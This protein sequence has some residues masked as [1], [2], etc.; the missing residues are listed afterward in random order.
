MLATIKGALKSFLIFVDEHATTKNYA[1]LILTLAVLDEFSTYILISKIG[2]GHEL[3]RMTL[4]IWQRLG[5]NTIGITI[6]FLTY[7]FEVILVI[8]FYSNFRRHKITLAVI[9]FCIFFPTIQA[10][11]IINRCVSY[12]S[13]NIPYLSISAIPTVQIYEP[14]LFASFYLV[15]IGCV[16]YI[17]K[18][19]LAHQNPK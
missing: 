7:L 19:R 13:P 10:Y 2:P 8:F 17:R 14:I 16:Y 12:L 3:N 18:K 15:L 4:F 1:V 11:A 5:Y 9:S 6:G